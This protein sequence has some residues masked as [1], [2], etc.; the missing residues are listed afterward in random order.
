[1]PWLADNPDSYGLLRLSLS[2]H[3]LIDNEKVFDG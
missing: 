3:V 2:T 1:M